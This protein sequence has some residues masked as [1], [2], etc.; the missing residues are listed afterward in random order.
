MSRARRRGAPRSGA[1][2][3]GE[4]DAQGGA[5]E[6]AQVVVV[7]LSHLVLLL[8]VLQQPPR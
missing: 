3:P 4:Q 2:V 8:R 5:Q 1:D 6:G 7:L